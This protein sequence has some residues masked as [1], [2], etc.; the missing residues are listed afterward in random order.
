MREDINRKTRMKNELRSLAGETF[1]YASM[2]HL[3]ARI[4]RRQG[5]W[6]RQMMNRRDRSGQTDP[7][8][9]QAA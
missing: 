5:R 1:D 9:P 7:D 3:M 6:R 8:L 2:R 4:E